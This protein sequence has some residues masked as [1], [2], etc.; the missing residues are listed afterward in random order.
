MKH[1]KYTKF[2]NKGYWKYMV[3]KRFTAHLTCLTHRPVTY[4]CVGCGFDPSSQH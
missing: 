2:I 4:V 3:A 1:T